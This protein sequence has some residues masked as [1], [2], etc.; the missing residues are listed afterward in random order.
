MRGL[1][2]TACLL[3]L[4]CATDFARAQ[5]RSALNPE[6]SFIGDT[7]ALAADA[8]E[9]DLS[10]VL[11]ELEIGA[12]A[13]LNPFSSGS[14][15]VGLHEGEA[16]VEEAFVLFSALP[17]NLSLRGGRYYV[18]AGRYISQHRHTFSF[19]D[20]PLFVREF[21]GDEGY[22]DVGVNPSV[23]FDVGGAALTLSGN[24]MA[25]ELEEHDHGHDDAD[26]LLT[27]EDD[28]PRE[29]ADLAYTGRASLFLTLGDVSNLEVGGN[30][31][32]RTP[33]PA[34]DERERFYGGDFKY[35][36]RP[37]RRRSFTVEGEAQIYE[38]EDESYFGAFGATEFQFRRHWSVGA[39][40][41]TVE[42]PEDDGERQVGYGGFATYNLFEESTLV[43]LLL[44]QDDLPEGE[45][46]IFSVQLQLIFSM[47]P[48][49]PHSY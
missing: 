7:R 10:F 35:K 40:I 22:Q 12:T 16:H 33:H 45:E 42:H 41:D 43:R 47:G 6:I 20:Y 29:L 26:S 36:W 25:G 2:T 1:S 27:D 46:D 19:L 18:D 11:E 9:D 37:D 5:N 38:V 4:L 39:L 3:A 14:V 13:Y 15:Y 30:W 31:G 17:G 24:L 8:T 34:E 48:H 32:Q 28:E 23:L 44:R 49:K 21:H